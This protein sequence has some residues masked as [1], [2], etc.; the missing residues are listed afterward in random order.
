MPA[1]TPSVQREPV[2]APDFPAGFTWLNTDHP[3]SLKELRGRVVVLDFWTYCCINCQHILPDLAFLEEKY[4][5]APFTVIGVH[6]AK[7]DNEQEPANIRDA[8]LRH[9]I[10]H[11]VVVDEDHTIWDA[12]GVRGWPTLV[13]LDP[14]GYVLGGVSGEGHRDLLDSTI[15][16]VLDAYGEK[17][18]LSSAAL[19]LPL[20]RD[21]RP[22]T[23]LSYPG[24]V[25]ADAASN[26]LCIADSGYHRIII[27]DLDGRP[28]E[29]IGTGTPGRDDGPFEMATFHSPQ[30]MLLV[31]NVLYVADTENHLIRRLDLEARTVQTVAGTGAQGRGRERGGPALQTPLNSPWDLCALAGQ[32]YIAMAGPH[33]IWR[34]DPAGGEV[35]VFAG[36]GGEARIDGPAHEA[37]FAQPSG[38][39]TDGRQLFV[40][41]SEISSVR[42]VSTGQQ[43]SVQTLAGGD[44]FAFG[45][46]DGVGD[47]VRLQ[48]P[49]GIAHA[50]GVLYLADTYNHK[51]KRVDPVSGAVLTLLGDGTAGDAGGERPRFREPGGLSVAADRLYIADTNNHRI[52]VADLYAP[53]V[54]GAVR[55]LDLEGLCA[56]GI[57]V[58]GRQQR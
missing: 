32:I 24:K 23:A 22:I 7:F 40:A 13:L 20:E 34:F 2:R 45:D 21:L 49:L 11:P 33:Q 37:A 50:D 29:V 12:Y 55:T 17:G 36:S 4:A 3:L 15:A 30:G 46:Q 1:T 6:S 25:L 51:I 35:A 16:Q 54:A 57:C 41:D 19:T 5:G 52:Q 26:R 43:P 58:P 31:D 14:R 48:H 38:I 8:I 10:Q 28:L 9:G 44:L 27:S 39:A 18:L 42:V 56:P 47:T 53:G